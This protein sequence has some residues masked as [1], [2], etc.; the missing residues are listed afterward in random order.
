MTIDSG[1]RIPKT[2]PNAEGEVDPWSD[3]AARWRQAG[4]QNEEAACPPSSRPAKMDHVQNYAA[5][6]GMGH[7]ANNIPSCLAGLPGWFGRLA[8]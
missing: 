1:I 2:P 4:S 6:V 5:A 3:R 8:A 7:G